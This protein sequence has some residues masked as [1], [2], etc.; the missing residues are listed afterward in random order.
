MNTLVKGY[1]P[2][3]ITVLFVSLFAMEAR[4][5]AQEVVPTPIVT[6]PFQVESQIESL[7]MET[8]PNDFSFDSCNKDFS[9]DECVSTTCAD[10]SFDGFSFD[11]NCIDEF[12]K[13]LSFD[14][15]MREV[16]QD[17]SFDSD[18]PGTNKCPVEDRCANAGADA[19][20]CEKEVCATGVSTACFDFS[21][22]AFCDFSFDDLPDDFSFDSCFQSVCDS[23][24]SSKKSTSEGAECPFQECIDRGLDVRQCEYTVCKDGR[25]YDFCIPYNSDTPPLAVKASEITAVAS[26]PFILLMTVA[27]LSTVSFASYRK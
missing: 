19:A 26:T 3:V 2:W 8:D 23:Y 27:L 16:C 5:N 20:L 17:F 13:D 14:T 12:C 7:G 4:A 15:C 22:D 24:T 6:A 9:F 10:F 21:F 25:N 1:W 11:G 18:A